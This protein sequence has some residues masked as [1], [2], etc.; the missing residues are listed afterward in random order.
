M[1]GRDMV[2]NIAIPKSRNYFAGGFTY[3]AIAK[4]PATKT[5]DPSGWAVFRTEDA[6]GH[7]DWAKNTAGINTNE[8][9]FTG[10][11]AAVTGLDFT[12]VS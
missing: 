6:T 2:A 9:V 12:E 7:V 3:T 1:L 8:F 10:T 4:T 5:T 11:E